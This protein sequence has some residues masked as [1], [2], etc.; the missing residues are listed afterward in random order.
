MINF[1]LQTDISHER[2]KYSHFSYAI[3]SE[4]VVNLTFK[5]Y[6]NAESTLSVSILNILTYNHLLSQLNMIIN[7]VMQKNTN[8]YDVYL[9]CIHLLVGLMFYYQKFNTNATNL[10]KISVPI[11]QTTWQ[12]MITFFGTFGNFTARKITD[13]MNL[14]HSILK[15]DENL[16]V[17]KKTIDM[18]FIESLVD[19]QCDLDSESTNLEDPKVKLKLLIVKIL[20]VFAVKAE[21]EEQKT[22]QLMLYEFDD[23]DPCND[24]DYQQ[25]MIILD[26]I[27]SE[28]CQLDIPSVTAI[29]I[30]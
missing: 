2:R 30:L 11:I 4:V 3:S 10:M 5:Y 17:I 27:A 16:G 9:N 22:V 12:K 14:F 26:G 25:A 24:V 21:T 19:A 8:D 18:S 6:T 20:T 7:Q 15:M 1:I 13:T 28:N 29:L 23:F